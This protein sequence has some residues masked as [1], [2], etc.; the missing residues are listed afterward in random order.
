[1]NNTIDRTVGKNNIYSR[2]FNFNHI[3]IEIYP[4]FDTSKK[5][6]KTSNWE[7]L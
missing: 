7:V 4:D 2:N 3:V 5:K 6:N 1:M